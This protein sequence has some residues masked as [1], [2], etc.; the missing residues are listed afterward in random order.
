MERVNKI[1]HKGKEIIF[2]D[3]SNVKDE[4]EMI[5][6]HKSHLAFVFSEN[7]RYVYC[8]DYTGAYTTPKYMKEVNDSLQNNKNLIIKGAFLGVTGAKNIILSGVIRLFRLNF[9]S[10]ED[11]NSALDYLVS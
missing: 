10:F 9:K 6:I 7:K 3:Y 2:V 4:N 1:Y 8:A 5:A 11:K